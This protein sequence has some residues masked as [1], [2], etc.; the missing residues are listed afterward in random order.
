MRDET[1]TRREIVLRSLKQRGEDAKVEQ[2]VKEMME[3]VR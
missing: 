1:I 3:V 2:R